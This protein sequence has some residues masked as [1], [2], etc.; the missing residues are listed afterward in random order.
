MKRSVLILAVVMSIWILPV[1]GNAIPIQIAASSPNGY[2]DVA[3]G[4]TGTYRLDY[5]VSFDGGVTWDQAFCIDLN[6]SAPSGVTEY[7]LDPLPAEDK[8]FLE[9]AKYYKQDPKCVASLMQWNAVS[10]VVGIA[11]YFDF[12][13]VNKNNGRE[14][15]FIQ[16]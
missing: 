13:L 1:N 9:M 11:K 6:Q 12:E 15:L 7:S 3:S 10:S 4:P 14:L 8:Y 16:K 5:D 2:I